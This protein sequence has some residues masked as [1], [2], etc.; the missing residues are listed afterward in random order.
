MKEQ[1]TNKEQKERHCGL[2]PQSPANS[3]SPNPSKGGE[4]ATLEVEQ[5]SNNVKPSLFPPLVAERSR[6]VGGTKGGF[7]MRKQLPL[8]RRGLGGGASALLRLLRLRSVTAARNDGRAVVL[9]LFILLSISPT[10][11]SQNND[12]VVK[13]RIYDY[14]YAIPNSIEK[15]FELLDKTMPDNEIELIR[16]LDEDSI[17]YHPEFKR[18]TDFFHAWKIYDGSEL[19]EYFNN[20]GLF[21][22]FEIYESILIS[23]HRYLN[24]KEIKLEEQ[25]EKYKIIQ[26]KE[27]KEYLL[28]TQQDSIN[29]IYIPMDLEDC[30]LQ[31]DKLLSNKD[32]KKIKAL[33]NKEETIKHHHGLGMWLRNNWGLWGGSR[34]QKYLLEKGIN[35]PDEMSSLILVFYHDWLNNKNNEWKDWINNIN[36]E[37][38]IKNE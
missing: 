13:Q 23:Y 6:S 8:F 3:T 16:I 30:F 29:G 22:S 37:I 18:G 31:L 1:I 7:S 10:V 14:D 20:K 33:K 32:K 11:F 15:C 28:L 2:D 21:G 24:N 36:N 27:Y 5:I 17:Y 12:R 38:N 25:I 35:H 4:Q 26:Q 19:T 34:L 9:L